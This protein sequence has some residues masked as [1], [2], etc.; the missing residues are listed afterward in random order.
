MKRALLLVWFYIVFGMAIILVSINTIL[1]WI[2][3]P[4][5]P[6]DKLIDYVCSL[7]DELF[8]EKK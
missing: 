8:E 4:N 6:D 1:W 7:Q 5:I 3:L 2:S